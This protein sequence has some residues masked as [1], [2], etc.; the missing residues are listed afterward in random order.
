MIWSY[1][2]MT[3]KSRLSSLLPR[4]LKSLSRAGFDSP[5]VFV[6][7]CKD[8]NLLGLQHTCRVPTVRT[9]GN[10][11]LSM[12]ELYVRC[13][14]ADRYALFQDDLLACRNLREYLEQCQYPLNGYLNLLTFM[15][16]E[17]ADAS[18]GW[19]E[20]K[21]ITDTEDNSPQTGRGAVA[22]VFDH[23]AV[24]TL[25][26]S[27]RFIERHADAK[28]GWRKIDGGIVDAM[29]AAGYREFV[30]SPSLVQHIGEKSSMGIRR[31]PTANTFPGE[32]FDV[33]SLLSV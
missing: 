6:D 23:K 4:T 17:K 8:V 18:V 26:S 30:H 5:R 12:M 28:W 15:D 32:G 11:H 7:G 20:S 10:W 9:A 27:R 2:V 19:R 13:P 22:L 31:Y 29:N 21:I 16:N 24:T 25:L 33:M 1:G 14:T 3:V